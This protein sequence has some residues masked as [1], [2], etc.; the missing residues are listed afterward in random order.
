MAMTQMLASLQAVH[1]K[2]LVFVDV[3][4]GN[5]IFHRTSKFPAITVSSLEMC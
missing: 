2:G 4:P 3:R 1:A 5:F